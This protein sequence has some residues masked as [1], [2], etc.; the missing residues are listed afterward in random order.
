MEIESY[1]KAYEKGDIL[2]LKRHV[3]EDITKWRNV[4]VNIA[5]TGNSGAGKSSFINSFRGLKANCEGA[6]K[7]GV[8]ETTILPTKYVHP[9]NDNLALWDLPGLGTQNFPKRTYLQDV[10]F[11][12]YDFFLIITATRFTENDLWLAKEV[13]KR[14]KKFFFIR[15][16]MSID[17]QN[18][19]Y[20]NPKNS[21]DD[22]VSRVREA[23]ENY[24]EKEELTN[25]KVFLIDNHCPCDYDYPDFLDKMIDAVPQIK[26]EAIT[27]TVTHLTEKVIKKKEDLMR[28]RMYKVAICSAVEGILPLPGMNIVVDAVLIQNEINF[29]KKQL[30]LDDASLQEIARSMNKT[31]DELTASINVEKGLLKDPAKILVQI[32]KE[33]FTR[34]GA[35]FFASVAFSIFGGLTAAGTSYMRTVD[36]LSNSLDKLVPIAIEINR[37]F[38]QELTSSTFLS[39][40]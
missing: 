36:F 13:E 37:L 27:L 14:G 28:E 12:K 1:K 8:E 29:Y 17:V 40:L 19:L 33:H 32:M 5:I 18:D 25:V 30:R 6:A 11:D 31:T 22:T 10:K 39:K 35:S 15:S 21:K 23:M 3:E 2:K 24:I 16:K 26:H 20:D 34:K 38:I 9:V 4:P 7:V